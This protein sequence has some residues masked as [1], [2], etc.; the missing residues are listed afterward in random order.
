MGN[1]IEIATLDGNDMMPAYRAQPAGTP[2]GA[3]VVIQ[4]IFGINAGI[5]EKADRWAS[6]GYLAI[7]PDLFWRMEPGVELD[8]DVPEEMER[9][10]GFYKQFDLD[11]AMRDV[12]AT[13][14]AARGD[15]EKVG[16]VGYCLGGLIAYL[17]ATR[18]DADASVGYYGGG[19]NQKLGE[20]HAIGKPLMLHFAGDDHFIDAAAREAIG[21]GLRSNSHV[22]IHDYAGVDHG[23]AATSGS[24]RVDDAARLAD[25]RT[26]AFFAEH[27]G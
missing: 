16:V 13:I 14:K 22:T 10:F 12:E 20:A 23:F 27:I 24:R 3:I 21:E 26:E 25:G 19:I 7:A 2:K 8:P 15:A 5:R 18:T 4:E 9:A 1:R 6:L 17:A 11:A